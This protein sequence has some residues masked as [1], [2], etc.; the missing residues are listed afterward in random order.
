[1]RTTRLSTR[2]M[3][4][5]ALWSQ[6]Y[7]LGYGPGVGNMVPP[8][9][10]SSPCG[11][12][13]T[14]LWKHYLPKTS[15]VGGSSPP[16]QTQRLAPPSSGKSWTPT[17]LTDRWNE[18]NR[19]PIGVKD[20]WDAGENKIPSDDVIK[21]AHKSGWRHCVSQVS[22]QSA[23]RWMVTSTQNAISSGGCQGHPPGP[24][25][26]I[27][28]QFMTKNVQNNILWELAPSPQENP[29]SAPEGGTNS[30]IFFMEIIS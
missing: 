27:C 22:A 17:D 8:L 18:D 14:R 1:M 25:S 11:Q 3:A 10:P 6:S 26:F 5:G 30:T 12:N 28:M 7:G 2:D 16:P 24:N 19:L 13:D 21:V 29:G 15:L 4:G 23:L 20:P 9:L